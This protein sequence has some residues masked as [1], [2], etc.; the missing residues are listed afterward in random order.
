MLGVHF[1]YYNEFQIFSIP[2]FQFLESFENLKK[3]KKYCQKNQ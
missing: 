1:R 2:Q 3:E